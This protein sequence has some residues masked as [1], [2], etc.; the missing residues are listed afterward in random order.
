MA[1]PYVGSIYFL[2]GRRISVYQ[3][4]NAAVGSYLPCETAGVA[5][6]T[7]SYEFS[8]PQGEVWQITDF[9]TGNTA[10]EFEVIVDGQPSGR[11]IPT[12][13]SRAPAAANRPPISVTLVPGKRYKLRE[14][15]A[16]AA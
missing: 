2:N 7:S 13:A 6:S 14:T 9:T 15:V 3:A 8:V 1:G 5:T 11:Y 12:D 4:A 16:G 10:G